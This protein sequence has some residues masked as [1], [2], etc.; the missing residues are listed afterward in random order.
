MRGHDET[1][2]QSVRIPPKPWFS[3]NTE[4]KFKNRILEYF[5]PSQY[6]LHSSQSERATKLGLLLFDVELNFLSNGVLKS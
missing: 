6:F 2:E 5:L 4:T 1:E 3:A